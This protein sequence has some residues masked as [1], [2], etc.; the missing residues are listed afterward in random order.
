MS[1]ES[2]TAQ[3]VSCERKVEQVPLLTLNHRQGTA[4]ICPQCL[5]ILIHNPQQLL[6]KLP[7][8]EALEPHEH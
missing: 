3:C 1:A 4:Y 6:S 8:A 7:G 5:P 2:T